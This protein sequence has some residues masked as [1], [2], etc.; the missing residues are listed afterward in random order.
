TNVSF[1]IKNFGVTVDGGF[2]DVKVKTNFNSNKP[3]ESY[4]NATIVV[5]SIFTGINGR[6]KSLLKKDYFDEANY[7][8]I[9]LKSTKIEKTS[10]G[11]F[12]LFANLTIKNTTKKIEIPMEVSETTIGYTLKVNFIINRKEYSVGGGSFIMSKKVKIQVLYTGN[13]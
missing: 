4:L 7:K 1:K 6:D 5:K 12:T 2:S 11:K 8:T 13:L 10:K 9:Q 3:S